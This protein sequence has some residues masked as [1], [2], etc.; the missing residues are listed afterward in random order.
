ML[1]LTLREHDRSSHFFP[2]TSSASSNAVA[3]ILS[4]QPLR[5][6]RAKEHLFHEGDDEK[7]IYR[8]ECGLI[9][10]YK[11]LNDGRRQI[12]AFRYPGDVL[13]SEARGERDYSAEAVTD[14]TLRSFSRQA[15]KRDELVFN[16]EMI[17]LL[18]QELASM[19]AQVAV[20]NRR[21]AIEKLSAFVLDIHRRQEAQSGKTLRLEMSRADIADFLG[22]TIE[23]VSRNFTKL[24]QRRIID[25]PDIHSIII[26]DHDRLEALAA[27]E[28][29]EW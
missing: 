3:S 10:L 6:L 28:C 8:V 21:S 16:R 27:G 17:G 7:Q 14:V 20:L 4:Q 15:A 2:S 12:I 23:T 25:L 19:R 24:R 5:Q 13:G 22:L 18:T 29:D 1:N 26:R 11:L 9:R